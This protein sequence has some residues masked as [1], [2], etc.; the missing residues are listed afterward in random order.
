MTLLPSQVSATQKTAQIHYTD[1]LHED[2]TNHIIYWDN[3]APGKPFEHYRFE[4]GWKLGFADA[5]AF[6][7][8]RHSERHI[9]GGNNGADVIGAL[10]LW[11]RKRMKDSASI[12]AE[13]GWEFEQGL[14]RGVKAFEELVGL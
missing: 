6:W 2:V 3:T 10:D 9:S 14:R 7:A 11:V 1:K 12:G 4:D 8:W 5:E 13:F